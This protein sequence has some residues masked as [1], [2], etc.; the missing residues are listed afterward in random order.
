MCDTPDYFT[1]A[2]SR[3]VTRSGRLSDHRGDIL[4]KSPPAENMAMFR[5]VARQYL[6]GREELLVDP[7]ASPFYASRDLLKSVPPLYFLVGSEE[8]LLGDSIMLAQRAAA[9]G[10][11]IV[12]DVYHGMWHDFPMY[13][14]GCG[15]AAGELWLGK[16]AW[17]NTAEFIRSD[18]EG[19][20]SDGWPLIRY[21]YDESEQGRS[22]W[23]APAQPLRLP[24]PSQPLQPPQPASFGVLSFSCGLAAGAVVYRCLSFGVARGRRRPALQID[25]MAPS[26]LEMTTRH[27]FSH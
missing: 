19:H 6:G 8:T 9:F 17:E 7:V 20:A 27:D 24:Q 1:N 14:E 16:K 26:T 22:S 5:D 4:F 2:Y 25:Q 13:S 21:I 23:F 11:P 15:S 12:V 10:V 18:R 3:V